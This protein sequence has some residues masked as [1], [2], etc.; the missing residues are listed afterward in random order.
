MSSLETLLL[1]KRAC[2]TALIL[3]KDIKLF[4]LTAKGV[5]L[6]DLQGAFQAKQFSDATGEQPKKGYEDGEGYRDKT[7]EEQ[8]RSFDLFSLQMRRLRGALMVAYSLLTRGGRRA[9]ADLW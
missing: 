6:D 4:K 7:Y 2:S 3:Q 5:E 8:L 1:C 9:G